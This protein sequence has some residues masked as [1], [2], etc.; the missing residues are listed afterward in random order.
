[1]KST[2]LGAGAL[3]LLAAGI[4]LLSPRLLS[5]TSDPPRP[6]PVWR[7]MHSFELQSMGGQANVVVPSADGILALD[8]ALEVSAIPPEPVNLRIPNLMAEDF[9]A[10]LEGQFLAGSGTLQFHFHMTDQS[11]DAVIVSSDGRVGASGQGKAPPFYG[12]AKRDP[13]GGTTRVT[14]PVDVLGSDFILRLRAVRSLYFV[15]INQRSF[16]AV[17][18]PRSGSF[19][20]KVAPDPAAT[21]PLRLRFSYL[22]ITS[23]GAV[24]AAPS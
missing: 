19:G 18:E 5:Q 21:E 15:Y 14:V 4:M 2:A 16:F 3:A 11:G 20:I 7:E 13:I 9:E 1:V 6:A 23:A 17:T 8:D 24:T 12:P 10:T 22:K